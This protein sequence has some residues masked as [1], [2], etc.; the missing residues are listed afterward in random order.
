M[1]TNQLLPRGTRLDSPKV[2]RVLD[3]AANS[4]LARAAMRESQITTD[5]LAEKTG[6][7]VNTILRFLGLWYDDSNTKDPR[8]STTVKVFNA[9]GFDMVLQ[10]RK[11]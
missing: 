8:T 4:R 2:N 6:L 9:L 7:H 11:L 5:Q 1:K 10:R 3:H